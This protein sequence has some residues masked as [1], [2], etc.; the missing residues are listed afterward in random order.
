[1]FEMER[2]VSGVNKGDKTSETLEGGSL[3][4]GLNEDAKKKEIMRG[5][6]FSSPPFLPFNPPSPLF[7]DKESTNNLVCI[8][9]YKDGFASE[10]LSEC[11]KAGA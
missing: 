8:R 7:S 5:F 3:P 4:L 11:E 2:R 1:M 9:R 10:Y 6:G